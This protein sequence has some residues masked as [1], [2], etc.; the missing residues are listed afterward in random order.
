MRLGDESLNV[1]GLVV[2]RIRIAA[3]LETDVIS[4]SLH[5]YATLILCTSAVSFSWFQS[6]PFFEY[7]HVTNVFR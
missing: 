5:R 4:A 2:G 6:T 3:G 1:V 7:T